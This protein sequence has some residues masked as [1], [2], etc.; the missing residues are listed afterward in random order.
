MQLEPKCPGYCLKE[1][2]G[3]F[4]NVGNASDCRG[5]TKLD[6]T[7]LRYYRLRLGVNICDNS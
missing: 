3:E 2:C 7:S 6:R 1:I 4:P 5:V